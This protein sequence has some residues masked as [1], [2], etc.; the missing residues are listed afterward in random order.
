MENKKSIFNRFLSVFKSEPWYLP[1]PQIIQDFAVRFASEDTSEKNLFKQTKKLLVRKCKNLKSNKEL[2][3]LF[4]KGDKKDKKN[5]VFDSAAFSKHLDAAIY[6]DEAILPNLIKIGDEEFL[7]QLFFDIDKRPES[8]NLK[9]SI[10]SNP[11]CPIEI[12]LA[13]LSSEQPAELRKVALLRP[14]ASY[15]QKMVACEDMLFG[16][17]NLELKNYFSQNLISTVSDVPALMDRLADN[18]LNKRDIISLTLQYDRY[19][20]KISGYTYKSASEGFSATA[21]LV[22]EN[23]VMFREEVQNNEVVQIGTFK[24]RDTATSFLKKKFGNLPFVVHE[25]VV[26]ESELPTETEASNEAEATSDETTSDKK[27]NSSKNKKN[28][29]K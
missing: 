27:E 2:A 19:I 23:T 13:A 28:K 10:V 26:P 16:N 6:E 24:N 15:T 25:F 9:I 22:L 12:L 7:S 18:A 5:V 3:E 1:F 4:F 21:D 29:K 8:T 17:S 20:I 14:E 11:K